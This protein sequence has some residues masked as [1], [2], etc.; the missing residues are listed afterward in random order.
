MPRKK[1]SLLSD[2]AYL[3]LVS[4]AGILE[5][6]VSSLLKLP[7]VNLEYIKVRSYIYSFCHTRA[8]IVKTFLVLDPACLH[9]C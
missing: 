5:Q 8:L 2:I 1:Y 4:F 6:S 7:P 3:H 9:L